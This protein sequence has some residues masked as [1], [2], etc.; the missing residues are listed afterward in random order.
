MIQPNDPKRRRGRPRKNPAKT[1]YYHARAQEKEA[2]TTTLPL[3]PLATLEK[4]RDA[5]GV[6]WDAFAALLRVKKWT[7][8][9]NWQSTDRLPAMAI[10][11]L[12]RYARVNPDY[13]TGQSPDVFRR[14]PATT[15]KDNDGAREV[16][17]AFVSVLSES[18][19]KYARDLARA[20]NG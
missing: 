9:Y 17:T 4:V 2:T 5:L 8:Q 20:L 19:K 13:L 10:K 3:P 6:D 1:S 18:E 12:I 11:R 14:A 16:L 7:I 15:K